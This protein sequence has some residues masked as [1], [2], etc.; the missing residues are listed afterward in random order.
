MRIRLQHAAATILVASTVT[1]CAGFGAQ[2]RGLTYPPE[3]RYIS[4][5]QLDSSMWRLADQIRWLDAT[6]RDEAR[7][8]PARQQMVLHILEQLSAEAHTLASEGRATN[9][10]M[11]DEHLPRLQEDI[12]LARTAA[13]LTPPQYALA[14]SVAGACVYCHE[15]RLPGPPLSPPAR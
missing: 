13:A 8:E 4:G 1:A 2:V 10:P 12:A 15:A 11:L 7:G 3:F 9:H 5:K 14:G 6:L